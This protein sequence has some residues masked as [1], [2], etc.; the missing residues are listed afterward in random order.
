MNDYQ[1]GYVIVFLF[2]VIGVFI[3]FIATMVF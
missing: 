3:P 1:I 2:A